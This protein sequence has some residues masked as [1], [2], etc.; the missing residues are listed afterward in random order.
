MVEVL[1]NRTN[2]V[3]SAK[4]N[5]IYSKFHGETFDGVLFHVHF[6]EIESHPGEIIR[7]GPLGI[8]VSTEANL[9]VEALTST[10]LSILT[11]PYWH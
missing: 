4:S 9:T 5:W 10:V 3:E 7:K 6:R 1:V 11:N 8:Y 2:S